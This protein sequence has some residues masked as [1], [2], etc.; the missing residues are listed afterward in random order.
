MRKILLSFVVSVLLL[1]CASNGQVQDA[2]GS[3]FSPYWQAK[4]EIENVEFDTLVTLGEERLPEEYRLTEDELKFLK[5]PDMI[6]SV[7]EIYIRNNSVDD[8]VVEVLAFNANGHFGSHK[9]HEYTVKPGE[10][11]KTAPHV[12]VS[13]IYSAELFNYGFKCLINGVEHDVK[14]KTRRLTVEELER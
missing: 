14:G 4:T 7:H 8:V 13:S 11:V 5:S 1:G 3:R 12:S 10:W 2:S 6:E 9:G